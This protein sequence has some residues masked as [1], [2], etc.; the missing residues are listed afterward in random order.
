[1]AFKTID[2]EWC[3]LMEDHRYTFVLDGPEDVASLPKC[4]AGSKA[5]VAAKDGA[6][7]MVNAS[8]EWEEL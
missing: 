3:A 4:C 7:F 1:M 2:C 8:G 5:I 6:I